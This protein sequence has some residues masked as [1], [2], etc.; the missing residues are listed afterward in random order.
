[1]SRATK[2]TPS[3]SD[4]PKGGQQENKI[5][6]A[7]EKIMK[8]DAEIN[9]EIDEYIQV[10][11]EVKSA[12]SSITN[13]LYREVL[14]RKYIKGETFEQIAV[15]MNYTYRNVCYLHGKALNTVNVS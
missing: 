14:E 10:K 7:I 5:E 11:T 6:N 15:E 8:I 1:M 2:I 13:E 12:I 4:M 3:Y 9:N